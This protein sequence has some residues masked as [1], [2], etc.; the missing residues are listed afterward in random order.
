MITVARKLTGLLTCLL[1]VTRPSSNIFFKIKKTIVLGNVR[2]TW[3]FARH[4]VKKEEKLTNY[5]LF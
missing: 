1:S 3:M 4:I 2:S 5:Y